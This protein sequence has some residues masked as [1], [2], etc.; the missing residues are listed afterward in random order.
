M[1]DFLLYDAGFHNWV[2]AKVVKAGGW[3]AVAL[4]VLGSVYTALKASPSGGD[5]ATKKKP[6]LI[7]GIIFAIVPPLT[8]LVLGLWLAWVG[9]RWYTAVYPRTCTARSA[10]SPSPP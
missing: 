7:D 2:G 6:G 5:E 9:H 3:G 4:S 8:L 10:T 1:I